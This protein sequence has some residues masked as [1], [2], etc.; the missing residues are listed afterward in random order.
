MRTSIA[1]VAAFVIVNACAD[2]AS[3]KD[4]AKLAKSAHKPADSDPIV[5]PISDTQRLVTS[6]R[7]VTV[8]TLYDS[9]MSP[10]VNQRRLAEMYVVGVIDSSEGM[11]WCDFSQ[12]SPD[13]IQE[14]VYTALKSSADTT[15]NLR[16]STVITDRLHDLLPCRDA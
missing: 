14:Q 8:Q 2:S 16:A 10:N 12:A 15:P 1:F 7:A 3:D 6:N 9:Y 11:L 5:V 13:A 4:S